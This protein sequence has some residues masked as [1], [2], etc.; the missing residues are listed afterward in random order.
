[1][2]QFLGR[3]PGNS[4]MAIVVI[5]HLDPTYQAIMA[6][7][8]WRAIKKKVRQAKYLITVMP[9]CVSAI[10]PNKEMSILQ[11]VQ[12]LLP[13]VALRAQPRSSNTARPGL[14]VPIIRT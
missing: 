4:G 11:V 10:P 12:H 8:L 7:L 9:D 2:E 5:Q 3:V 1:M 6:K 13:P 14:G